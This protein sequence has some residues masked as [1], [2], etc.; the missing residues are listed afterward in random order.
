VEAAVSII[1]FVVIALACG[2]W[3]GSICNNKGRRERL[4]WAL[5]LILGL[6][7]VLIAWLLPPSRE[8][9]EWEARVLAD[10]ESWELPGAPG[11]ASDREA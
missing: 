5:G 10:A 3:A 11:T 4:G 2:A 1:V 8:F 7:G 6:I 9:R